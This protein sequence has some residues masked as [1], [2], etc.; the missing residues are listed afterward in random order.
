MQ[1]PNGA[2]S[3]R[4][5]TFCTLFVQAQLVVV[6]P[7]F[8]FPTSFRFLVGLGEEERGRATRE[9]LL[10]LIHGVRLSFNVIRAWLG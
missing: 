4:A 7:F 1:F 5:S 3:C 2:E 10:D 6:P 9:E 8:F